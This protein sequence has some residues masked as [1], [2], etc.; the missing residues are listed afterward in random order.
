[1]T[2]DP[3]GVPHAARVS[4]GALLAVDA[5]RLRLGLGEGTRSATHLRDSA[6]AALL[7]VDPELHLCV[8]ADAVSLPAAPAHPELARFELQ[9][10]EVFEARDDGPEGGTTP[11][12]LSLGESEELAA[13]R[14]RTVRLRR[15][16]AL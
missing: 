5:G 11:G 15:S 12:G 14:E 9:V 16:L 7:F 4:Y 2:T 6:R 10:R 1:M 3:Y 13:W 8:K